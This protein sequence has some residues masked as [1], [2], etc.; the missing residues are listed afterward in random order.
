VWRRDDDEKKIESKCGVMS[1]SSSSHHHH[2]S[3]AAVSR[4]DAEFAL[5]TFCIPEEVWSD[6]VM[7]ACGP[8][9]GGKT[10]M[11]IEW[12]KQR[13][14]ARGVAMNPTPDCKLTYSQYIPPSFTYQYFDEDV[15]IRWIVNQEDLTN[16]V[17]AE[18][19]TWARTAESDAQ[20]ERKRKWDE[21]CVRIAERSVEKKWT[22]E[23]I[24]R[25]MKTEQ[26]KELKR[27]DVHK[28]QRQDLYDRTRSNML[29]SV[30]MFVLL[31]DLSSARAAMRSELIRV[32]CD[33]GRHY[34]ME[35]IAS[36]QDVTSWRSECWGA[37]DFILMTLETKPKNLQRLDAKVG[38][39]GGWK[40]LGRYL[41]YGAERHWGLVYRARSC[42]QG[43]KK[44]AWFKAPRL[45]LANEYYCSPTAEWI[46]NM[47]YNEELDKKQ[48]FTREREK[49]KID[50]LR[51]MTDTVE[52]SRKRQAD[53]KRSAKA[54]SKSSS[55]STR[56]SS[57]SSKHDRDRDED[58]D[59]RHES[60]RR[61][62]RS[63]RS[64]S[65]PPKPISASVQ[66]TMDAMLKRSTD[67][68]DLKQ[69]VIDM[70]ASL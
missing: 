42:G 35:L 65:P 59:D 20:K 68:R 57:S 7:G 6:A 30:R 22:P 33:N 66:K 24:A 39:P 25:V 46:H 10:T 32:L 19:L 51:S 38:F 26:D 5:D 44:F 11:L 58:G 54:A 61:R 41:A 4:E 52:K 17:N 37:L 60:R 62:S 69:Q 49:E 12:L 1:S 47:V 9:K 14:L 23:E 63:S 56:R 3:S 45:F 48:E 55:S 50:Q 15:I 67:R 64:P 40:N 31:D 27:E 36:F 70:T 2:R 53:T 34:A 21:R 8:R 13:R 18:W 16:N 29:A 43:L 28:N